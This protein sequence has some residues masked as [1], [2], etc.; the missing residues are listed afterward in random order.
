MFSSRDCH[1]EVVNLSVPI[2]RLTTMIH[3]IILA[4][5]EIRIG[6]RRSALIH[7]L[8]P[9]AETESDKKG[10]RDVYE[11]VIP[12]KL[13]RCGIET[14][15]VVENGEIQKAGAS[16]VKSIQTAL[17]KG[18]TWNQALLTGKAS[19][20]TELAKREKVTRRYIGHLLQLAFLA[21]DIMQSIVKG[22]IPADLTLDRLEAGFPLDW[23]EQRKVLGFE[24]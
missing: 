16:S 2:E 12:V 13:K 17:S 22:D 4:C 21:P 10:D 11:T 14:R 24:P 19:S 18:L 5:R 20:M 6:I 8:I 15:L 23:N 7:M 9:K 1:P 3:R